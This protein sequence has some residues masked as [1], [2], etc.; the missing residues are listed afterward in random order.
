MYIYVTLSYILFLLEFVCLYIKLHIICT[1][2]Y[3][4]FVLEFIGQ[5]QNKNVYFIG[6][7]CAHVQYCY[8]LLKL[9]TNLCKLSH[10]CL[11]GMTESFTKIASFANKLPDLLFFPCEW[12]EHMLKCFKI[13]LSCWI[14]GLGSQGISYYYTYIRL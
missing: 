2:S 8:L 14:S 13:F 12:M 5:S 4:L 9:K 1:L 6:W 11:I 3:I 10:V 7:I